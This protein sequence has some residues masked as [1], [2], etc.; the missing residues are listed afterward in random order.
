MGLSV[1]VCAY[2][3]R[4]PQRSEEGAG[5]CGVGVAGGFEPLKCGYLGTESGSYARCPH[6]I[7]L[8]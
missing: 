2:E 4:C 6:I 8:T 7:V 3:C 5:L 1:G